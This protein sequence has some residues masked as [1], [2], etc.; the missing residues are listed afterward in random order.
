MNT[1][2]LSLLKLIPDQHI[3]EATRYGLALSNKI[4]AESW[5]KLVSGLAKIA[6]KMSGGRDTLSAWLGDVLAYGQGKY[7]GQITEYATAAGLSPGTLRD[8]KLVCSRIPVSCRHDTLSWSHHIEIGKAFSELGEIQRWLKI[9]VDEHLSKMELRRQIRE[10]VANSRAPKQSE[11]D[12]NIAVEPFTLLRELRAAGR[13]V[14]SQSAVW[15]G[16][17]PDTCRLAL[18][19]IETLADFMDELRTRSALTAAS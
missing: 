18:S 13:L 7:R 19:E 12:A 15:A 5:S 9:A 16:W 14:H 10:Y 6:G 11:P 8:A 1:D 4:D 2:H 3:N 17:T